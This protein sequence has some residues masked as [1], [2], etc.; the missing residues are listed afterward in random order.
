MHYGFADGCAAAVPS[1]P[2]PFSA[3]LP[4]NAMLGSGFPTS[5]GAPSGQAPWGSAAAATS[6][7]PI[8]RNIDSIVV[9]GSEPVFASKTRLIGSLNWGT[10]YLGTPFRRCFTVQGLR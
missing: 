3:T 2:R 10:P 5:G 8:Q 9:F 7:A 1:L 6:V 4:D